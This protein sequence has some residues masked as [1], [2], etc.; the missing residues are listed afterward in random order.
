VN[1][2]SSPENVENPVPEKK[3]F[4]KQFNRDDSSKDLNACG[5]NRN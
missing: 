4:I 3:D 5:Q 2:A 1:V